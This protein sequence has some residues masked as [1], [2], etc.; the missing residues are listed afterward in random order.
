MYESHLIAL[1]VLNIFSCFILTYR[2][3]FFNITIKAEDGT[4]MNCHKCILMARVEYFER[5]LSSNWIEVNWIINIT[6]L[7]LEYT[8]VLKKFNYFI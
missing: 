5:M 2:S 8:L 3:D 4:M 1:I 6:I 7:P